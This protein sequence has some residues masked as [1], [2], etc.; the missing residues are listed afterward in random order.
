MLSP[1]AEE[2]RQIVQETTGDIINERE[3]WESALQRWAESESGAR[4]L[5]N[6]A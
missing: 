4:V 5:R 1:T 2:V 6:G 3:D